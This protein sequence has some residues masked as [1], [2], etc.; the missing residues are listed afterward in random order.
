MTA[1]GLVHECLKDCLSVALPE[2]DA[3]RCG[4]YFGELDKSMVD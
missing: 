4:I 2:R 3:R 1:Q